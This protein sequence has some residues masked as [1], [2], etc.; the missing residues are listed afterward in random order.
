MAAFATLRKTGGD[1]IGIVC[2]LKILQVAGRTDRVGTGQIKVPV[3][4]TLG[5]RHGHVSASEGKTGGGMIEVDADPVVHP[6]ASLASCR[7]PCSHVVG[8]AG[9]FEL[10]GVARIAGCRE[11]RKLSHRSILVA[12]VA[13]HGCVRTNERKP[14]LMALDLFNRRHPSLHGVAGFAIGS[15]LALV[16]VGVTVGA[17]SAHVG[18]NRLGVALSA[19]H[20]LVKAAQW[21]A[22][23][24]VIE[25]RD[26]ANGFPAQ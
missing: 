14:V 24:I 12:G 8:I 10:V 9:L 11:T 26:G 7:E 20:A 1:V 25:F 6:V 2:L 23:A 5:A 22:G 4:V 16:N 13:L 19:A 17:F 3:Y 15:E 21:I 18:E